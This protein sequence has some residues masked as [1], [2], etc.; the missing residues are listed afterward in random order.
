MLRTDVD[1]RIRGS[2]R[3]VGR[4]EP[5]TGDDSAEDRAIAADR[6]DPSVGDRPSD[7]LLPAAAGDLGCAADLWQPGLFEPPAQDRH[8][9]QSPAWHRLWNPW[10]VDAAG[11]GPDRPAP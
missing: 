10:L 2:E 3:S 7:P 1:D 5:D 4:K 6:P 8:L 9:G 11:A